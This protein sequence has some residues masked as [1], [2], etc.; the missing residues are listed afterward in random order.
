[1]SPGV[2]TRKQEQKPQS[3]TLFVLFMSHGL[4]VSNRSGSLNRSLFLCYRSSR[5]G[6]ELA[7]FLSRLLVSWTKIQGAAST[8]SACI[9]AVVHRPAY[10]S[11]PLPS[12]SFPVTL[13]PSFPPHS[14]SFPLDPFSFPS[15]LSVAL[16][17]S[18]WS[19]WRALYTILRMHARASSCDP[20]IFHRDIIRSALFTNRPLTRLVAPLLA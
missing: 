10:F 14:L 1:M 6:C 15:S 19:K 4:F 9:L 11:L 17:P 20:Y 16:I 3:R 13:F 18:R 5:A 2:A 12:R 7:V 8:R